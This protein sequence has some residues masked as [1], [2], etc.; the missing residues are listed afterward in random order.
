MTEFGSRGGPR[1]EMALRLAQLII[2]MRDAERLEHRGPDARLA[3]GLI[4]VDIRMES[5]V[6]TMVHE[7]WMDA[8]QLA[9]S[10]EAAVREATAQVSIVKV[11]QDIVARQVAAVKID[12]ESK[13]AKRI[14]E[15]VES[16]IADATGN[17]L[18]TY[19][20]QVAEKLWDKAMA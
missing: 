20:Q 12:L 15:I 19:A 2:G 11:V 1:D 18:R 13:I 16:A 6:R 9:A 8:G 10:A 17:G 5:M 14:S 3:S 4:E 7:I